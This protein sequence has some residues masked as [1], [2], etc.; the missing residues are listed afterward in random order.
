MITLTDNNVLTEQEIDKLLLKEKKTHGI[1]LTTEKDFIL[2]KREI[3]RLLEQHT[4]NQKYELVKLLKTLKANLD[5]LVI[6]VERENIEQT[7]Y[8]YTL[9]RNEKNIVYTD[10]GFFTVHLL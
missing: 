10:S 7:V 3:N 1:R 5:E 4:I 8:S 6:Y 9:T 2:I